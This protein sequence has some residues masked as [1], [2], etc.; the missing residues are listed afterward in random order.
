MDKMTPSQVNSFSKIGDESCQ[1]VLHTGISPSSSQ[2]S[3]EYHSFGNAPIN[4]EGLKG[5][6]NFENKTS[7]RSLHSLLIG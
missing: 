4:Q 1:L 6:G 5:E 7:A 2:N 3:K